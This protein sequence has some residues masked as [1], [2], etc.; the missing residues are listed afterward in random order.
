M[1]QQGIDFA[2]RLVVF[3]IRINEITFFRLMC[4]DVE[5]VTGRR[6]LYVTMRVTGLDEKV[7]GII[8]ITEQIPI[9]SVSFVDSCVLYGRYHGSRVGTG[10]KTVLSEKALLCFE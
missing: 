2:R 3:G 6:L 4:G 7:D 1:I 10:Y 9:P 5:K 8:R